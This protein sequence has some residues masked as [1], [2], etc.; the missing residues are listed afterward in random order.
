MPYITHFLR[1]CDVKMNDFKSFKISQRELKIFLLV[2]SGRCNNIPFNKRTWK[3][4]D[5]NE[6][7]NERH[8]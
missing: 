5:L 6:V 2:E 7:G 4:C 8:V 1:V 3:N